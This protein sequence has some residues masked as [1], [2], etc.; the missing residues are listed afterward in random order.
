MKKFFL[1]FITSV[2]LASPFSFANEKLT[3][4]WKFEKYS[5]GPNVQY[6]D[7]DFYDPDPDPSSLVEYQEYS[8]FTYTADGKVSWETDAPGVQGVCNATYEGGSYSVKEGSEETLNQPVLEYTVEGYGLDI[9][10][11][12]LNEYSD[13]GID[14]VQRRISQIEG[15]TAS[16][17]FVLDNDSLYVHFSNNYYSSHSCKNG[18]SLYYLHKRQEQ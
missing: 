10:C 15:G 13:Q 12:R 4:V 18:G 16:Y 9:P 6:P 8:L 2:M 17:R 5:C 1:S 14:I 11:M 3:G 7:I